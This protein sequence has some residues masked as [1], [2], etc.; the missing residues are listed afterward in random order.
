MDRKSMSFIARVLGIAK[1]VQKVDA[2]Q[3]RRLDTAF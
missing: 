2:F 3:T 1:L